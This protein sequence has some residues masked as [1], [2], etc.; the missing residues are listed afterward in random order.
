[1]GPICPERLPDERNGGTGGSQRLTCE[2][3]DCEAVAPRSYYVHLADGEVAV[4]TGVTSLQVSDSAITILRGGLAST[5]FPRS[6]VYFTWCTKNAPP[7]P[8]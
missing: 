1:M 5:P 3:E 8:F 4:V 2:A 7:P 6:S